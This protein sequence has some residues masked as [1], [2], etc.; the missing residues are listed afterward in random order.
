MKISWSYYHARNSNKNPLGDAF[1]AKSIL[2]Q[3]VFIIFGVVRGT[4][5]NVNGSNPG[6]IM[7]N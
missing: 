1:F 2:P 3:S 6:Q 4:H 5:Y 7:T